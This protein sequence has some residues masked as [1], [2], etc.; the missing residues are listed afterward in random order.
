MDSKRCALYLRVSNEK[1]TVENQRLELERFAASQ[2]WTIVRTFEDSA[3]GSNGHRPGLKALFDAVSRREMDVVLVW[4][5]DRV[6]REGTAK[7]LEYLNKLQSYGVGFRSYQEACLDTVGPF[8][9]VILALFATFSKL[10]RERLIE[11]TR[12]GLKRAKAEGKTLGRP[13]L[14]VDR[15]RLSALR[16]KGMTIR[17]IAEGMGCSTGFVHK[18][19]RAWRVPSVGNTALGV[20][21]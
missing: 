19:L 2:G 15:A 14:V 12:A 3:T 8:G 11:R 6:T 5:C 20:A 16:E 13:K 17:E 7:L 21:S 10:E 18:T 9:D 1:L 4:A